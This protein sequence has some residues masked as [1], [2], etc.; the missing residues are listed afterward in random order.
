MAYDPTDISAEIDRKTIETLQRLISQYQNKEINARCFKIG[1]ETLYNVTAG[2]TSDGTNELVS[3]AMNEMQKIRNE[4]FEFK[5]FCKEHDV[6]VFVFNAENGLIGFMQGVLV[7]EAKTDL[8][9]FPGNRD[10]FREIVNGLNRSGF[11]LVYGTTDDNW[12]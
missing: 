11:T 9:K 3:D 4:C 1:V 6:Y 8:M 7:R 2:L 5:V 12:P 10:K